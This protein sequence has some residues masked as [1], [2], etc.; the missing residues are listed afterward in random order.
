MVKKREE[1][2]VVNAYDMAE[3]NNLNIE[4]V[5]G[6]SDVLGKKILL[7]EDLEHSMRIG[8][9]VVQE[10]ALTT[11][12]DE[13]LSTARRVGGEVGGSED[14]RLGVK[15]KNNPDDAA[16]LGNKSYRDDD[17]SMKITS[18]REEENNNFL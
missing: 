14:N 8:E 2:D 18:G 10:Q 7:S 11:L 3:S 5:K 17:T 13:G 6:D 15:V 4:N 16:A 1:S 9:E 12:A